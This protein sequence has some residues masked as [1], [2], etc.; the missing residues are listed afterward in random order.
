MM[1]SMDTLGTHSLETVAARGIGV[2]GYARD[3]LVPCVVHL[4]LGAFH[5]AHQ[6]LVF[7]ALLQAGHSQWGVHGIAMHSSVLADAL[8]EQ[9]GLY[10]VQIASHVATR[11]QVCGAVL[12]TSVAA[13]ERLLVVAAIGAAQTR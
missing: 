11:W 13:R 2:P 10:A 12:R 6:A 3:S 4:G 8:A 5:R 1:A 7:D 9:D